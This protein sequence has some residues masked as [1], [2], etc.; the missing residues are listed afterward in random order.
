MLVHHFLENSAKHYPNRNAIWFKDQWLTYAEINRRADSLAA[1]LVEHELR[2]GDR[3]ALLYENSFDYVISYFGI[4]KAGGVVVALNTETTVESINQLLV[5]CG[6]VCLIASQRYMKMVHEALLAG[7]C[8]KR[9]YCDGYSGT[10]DTW[11]C[12][13]F[14]DTINTEQIFSG[15]RIISVDLASIVYTSGSTGKPKGVMLTHQNLYDNTVSISN[16]LK[17][18]ERDRMMVVLPFYYIYGNSLLT[19]HFQVGGSLVIDNR[20]TFP[21]VVL[22][23]MVEQSVTGFAGVPSTF[24][25][26]LHKSTVKTMKFPSLQYITQAGGA[27]APNVQ[28]QVAEV[29]AP[30]KLYIMYGA[31]EAAPRLTYLE[32]EMLT[33]KLGSIGKAIPNVDVFVADEFGNKVPDG[34]AGEIVARGSNIMKGYWNDSEATAQVLRHGLYYSGD[35]GMVDKDGF[36]FIVGRSKDMIKVGGNRVSAKEIE[37]ALLTIPEIQEAAVIGVDDPILGEAIKAFL[38]TTS[39]IAIEEQYL[40][41]EMAKKIAQ[42]KFP[43]FIE[44]I[45]ELPKNE[46]GKIL[47]TMLKK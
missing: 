1:A 36:I 34:S 25:I 15:V 42:F 23:T 29:F 32:P 39:G 5:D 35:L 26:L 3:V 4:L 22:Q 44:Y 45:S 41:I 27:M 6:A 40:K 30:A 7:T 37:E 19:T 43:K 20:F 12:V 28:Q 47:K 18:T 38:V 10:D 16:Y 24:M 2:R 31:T 14:K 17:L 11:K 9:V 21:N 13:S 46:S 33:S 8:V